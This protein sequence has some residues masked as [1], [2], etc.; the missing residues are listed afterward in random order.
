MPAQQSGQDMKKKQVM[1]T[2]VQQQK[3]LT[4]KR[5][6]QEQHVT[7]SIKGNIKSDTQNSTFRETTSNKSTRY[8]TSTTKRLSSYKLWYIKLVK[9]QKTEVNVST[10]LLYS[11]N[12]IK[13]GKPVGL[14]LSRSIF[15]QSVTISLKEFILGTSPSVNRKLLAHILTTYGWA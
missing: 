6:M 1:M 7:K 13:R 15:F 9:I 4:P 10:D 11:D 12:R 3:N 8:N 14:K 5:R 2:N